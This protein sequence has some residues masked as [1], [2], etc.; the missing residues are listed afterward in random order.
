MEDENM[1]PRTKTFLIACLVTG[2]DVIYDKREFM[3]GLVNHMNSTERI[4]WTE[5]DED[6][7]IVHDKNDQPLLY[8]I[9][10]GER[11]TFRTFGEDEFTAMETR[12]NTAF[13]I[14]NVIDYI[15]KL[16]LEFCPS[17]LGTEAHAVK[18]Q[19]ASSDDTSDTEEEDWVL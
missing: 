17:V 13:A 1:D 4:Y 14:L 18:S 3:T 19:V 15:R 8:I 9:Y 6:G 5:G 10:T 2:I 12:A 11:M 16:E 7:V